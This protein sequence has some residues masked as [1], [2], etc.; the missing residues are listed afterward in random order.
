MRII[1]LRRA[2]LGCGL[3]VLALSAAGAA[4]TT[5]APPPPLAPV[6]AL[7]TSATAPAAAPDA[8]RAQAREI[9]AAIVGI[10]SSIGKGNV[11]QV[12][13]YLADRFKAGG[14]SGRGHPLSTPGRDGILGRTLPRQWQR[15]KTHCAHGAHGRGHREAQRLGT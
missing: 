14:F 15:R 9:F 6:L 2:A 3:G 8:E 11:P 12:A 13:K 10:E 7:G 1:G 5:T 4:T